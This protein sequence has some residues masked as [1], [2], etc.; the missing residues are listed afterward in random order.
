MCLSYYINAQIIFKEPYVK[1]V[2]FSII[3]LFNLLSLTAQTASD[4]A[5]TKRNNDWKTYL[6]EKDKSFKN[7]SEGA[8]F[9]FLRFE[10]YAPGNDYDY[11]KNDISKKYRIEKYD[12]VKIPVSDK[13]KLDGWFIPV[14]NAKGTLIIVPGYSSDLSFGL[15]QSRFLLEYGYQLLVYNPRMWNYSKK[16]KKFINSME[17]DLQ[18]IGD[19]IT[20]LSERP[21]VDKNKIGIFGFS[22]GALRAVLAGARYDQLK[23]VLE[24]AAP[25]D[26][27]WDDFDENA[28]E[29]IKK[30]SGVNPTDDIYRADVVAPKISPRALLILHG[31]KDQAVSIDNSE[32]IFANALEPKEFHTFPKSAHCLGMVQSDKA[33]YIKVV[34]DFLDK[35]LAK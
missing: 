24:D 1:K 23:V 13:L 2:L 17:K 4:K 10:G 30:Q 32:Q 31:G 7:R 22:L 5:R 16:P 6:T 34:T 26:R 12:E 27:I 25:K 28:I 15:Y 33:D 35:Y 18:D 9:H 8:V 20:F 29:T 21:D 19:I 3:I 11:V 14:E